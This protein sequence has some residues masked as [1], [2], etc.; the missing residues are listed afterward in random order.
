M[1]SLHPL[2]WTFLARYNFCHVV[3]ND[4]GIVS[5]GIRN[6]N[7]SKSYVTVLRG[8]GSTNTNEEA[9]LQILEVTNSSLCHSTCFP[10]SDFPTR[11]ACN[12]HVMPPY[13]TEVIFHGLTMLPIDHTFMVLVKH[14]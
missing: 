9:K 6:C 3:G 1:S 10:N 11:K 4:T 5:R 12:C 2:L 13:S 14:E 7:V 8:Y